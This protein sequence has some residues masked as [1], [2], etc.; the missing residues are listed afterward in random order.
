MEIQEQLRCAEGEAREIATDAQLAQ[1]CECPRDV[2]VQDDADLRRAFAPATI[3]RWTTEP[4][5][6][7]GTPRY[8]IGSLQVG[9]KAPNFDVYHRLIHLGPPNICVRARGLAAE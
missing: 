6:A 2:Y 8:S 1:C 5:C 3:E 4:H 9:D 7:D